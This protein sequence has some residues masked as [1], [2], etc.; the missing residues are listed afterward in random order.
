MNPNAMTDYAKTILLLVACGL[1]VATA[2]IGMFLLTVQ[3]SEDKRRTELMSELEQTIAA[4]N[5]Q[6]AESLEISRQVH[7]ACQN[8]DALL[9][10][11]LCGKNDV[12]TKS[13][14]EKMARMDVLR[15]ELDLFRMKGNRP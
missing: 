12:L 4:V 2:I 9:A 5:S 7:E 1:L 10:T 15:A 8:G 3:T 6:S 14:K 13:L 11:T